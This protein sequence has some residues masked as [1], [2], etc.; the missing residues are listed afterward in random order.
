MFYT[1]FVLGNEWSTEQTVQGTNVPWTIVHGTFVPGN[2]C[3][4]ERIVLRTN[5]PDTSLGTENM[6]AP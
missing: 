4:R 6:Y 1:R 3:S 2:E 5:V